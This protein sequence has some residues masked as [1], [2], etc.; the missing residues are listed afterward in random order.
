MN[1]QKSLVERLRLTGIHYDCGWNVEHYRGCLKSLDRLADQYEHA[2]RPLQGRSVLFAPCS[3]VNLEGQV[4][5][6]TGDVHR[7][8]LMFIAD[9][10]VQDDYLRRIPAYESALSH[11]LLGVQIARRKFMPKAAVRSYADHLNRV[12]TSML[13]YLTVNE[14]PKEWPKSLAEFELVVES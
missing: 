9:I 6:F 4:M 3:G 11:V 1:A 8:W 13:D 7:S 2:L 5:L 12:T 14:Y 10:G